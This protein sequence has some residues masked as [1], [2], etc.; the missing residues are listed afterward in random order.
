[1]IIL[2]ILIRLKLGHPVIFCQ[3]RPGKNMKIQKYHK[4]RSMSECCDQNGNLLSD[5]QRL[6]TFGKK[7]RST[8]LDELPQLFDIFMGKMSFVGPRPQTVENIYF[9]TADQK[10]RQQVTPGLTGLAQVRGRNNINWDDRVKYDLKYIENIS[11]L[12]D[13]KIII[14]TVSKVLKRKDINQDGYV[15][16]E[17]MGDYLLRTNQIDDEFYITRKTE[18]SNMDL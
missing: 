2:A 7:L 9:M 13:S 10:K 4:F 1:M 12:G 14:E 6:T 8:S 3:K 5:E 15:T 16:Y 18:I 17:S 11:F